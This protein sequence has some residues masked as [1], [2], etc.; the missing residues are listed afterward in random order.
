MSYNLRE[1]TKTYNDIL[2][3][4]TN[5]YMKDFFMYLSKE[6]FTRSKNKTVF[7]CR[8]SSLILFICLLLI[9]KGKEI[10][11]TNMINIY[12]KEYSSF[13]SELE[14]LIGGIIQNN[15]YPT[16]SNNYNVNDLPKTDNIY[17]AQIY[18][19][20]PDAGFL[21]SQYHT[22]LIVKDKNICHI[23]SSWYDGVDDEIPTKV[24]YSQYSY[25]EVNNLLKAQSFCDDTNY[26]KYKEMFGI[27]WNTLNYVDNVSIIFIP[28]VETNKRKSKNS[29]N[30]SL[31]NNSSSNNSS[32]KSTSNNSSSNNS[33]RKSTSNNS[34][35]KSSSNK[36]SKKLTRKS[37]SRKR[38]KAK[39]TKIHNFIN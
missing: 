24:I 26:D 8:R 7:S 33:S 32:R 37:S 10:T 28:F 21:F 27:K 29:S 25:I 35:R 3:C 19:R 18:L 5:C 15:K 20:Q 14:Y 38:K 13:F 12:I 9:R 11:K 1:L 31:S 30:I 16:I 23:L 34:S 6:Q 36:S 22:F 39:K 17:I 4:K 2:D